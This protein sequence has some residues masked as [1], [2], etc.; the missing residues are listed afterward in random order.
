[1]YVCALD[2]GATSGLTVEHGINPMDI[3]IG[4]TRNT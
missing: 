4:A 3:I 1:M 2:N